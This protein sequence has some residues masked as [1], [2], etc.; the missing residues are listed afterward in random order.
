M[1]KGATFRSRPRIRGSNRRST[2]I[3]PPRSPWNSLEVAK[4]LVSTSTTVAIF[5]V[6]YLLQAQQTELNYSRTKSDRE[7]ANEVV[8]LTKLLDKRSELWDKLGPLYAKINL[9]AVGEPLRPVARTEIQ[10]LMQKANE[11]VVAYQLYFSATFILVVDAYDEV[12]QRRLDGDRSAS[13]DTVW[14][15]YKAL[16]R[17]V[18]RDMFLNVD[19]ELLEWEAQ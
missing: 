7:Q 5:V 12:L 15:F 13:P 9:L 10:A 1:L 18:A 6:G 16:R 2:P 19:Q 8:K 3:L 17:A 11:L 4:L 14:S